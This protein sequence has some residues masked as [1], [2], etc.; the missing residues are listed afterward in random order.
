MF[1][2]VP[3]KGRPWEPA[4]K[5]GHRSTAHT[6]H[7]AQRTA[8]TGACSLRCLLQTLRVRRVAAMMLR[9]LH[10]ETRAVSL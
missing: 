4:L 5:A 9:A 6:A 2:F 8:Q 3:T 7:S 1:I 10:G